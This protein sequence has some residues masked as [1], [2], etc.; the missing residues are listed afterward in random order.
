MRRGAEPAGRLE[1]FEYEPREAA[2]EG[3]EGG[4]KSGREGGG[5]AVYPNGC[6]Q[7][8]GR[9]FEMLD[10]QV[11]EPIGT[12]ESGGG[13]PIEGRFHTGAG[14]RPLGAERG[15]GAGRYFLHA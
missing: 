8:A 10:R 1:G 3:E 14:N 13:A 6:R 7:G 11:G 9:R 4:E 12:D 15:E 5:K 2:V